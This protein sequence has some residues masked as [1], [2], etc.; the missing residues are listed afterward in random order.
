MIRIKTPKRRVADRPAL[1]STAETVT[2]AAVQDMPLCNHREDG[3]VD[4]SGVYPVIN[5]GN[6]CMLLR[7]GQQNGNKAL[8]DDDDLGLRAQQL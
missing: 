7:F 8:D 4:S 2:F 5:D 1:V 6:F 3:R